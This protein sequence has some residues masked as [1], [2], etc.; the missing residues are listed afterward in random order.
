M[1]IDFI[2]HFIIFLLACVLMFFVFNM[3]YSKSPDYSLDRKLDVYK[4]NQK[5]LEV[6]KSLK[7]KKIINLKIIRKISQKLNSG[8]RILISVLFPIIILI[9]AIPI[10]EM[11]NCC[12]V[13]GAFQLNETWWFWLISIG[14]IGYVEF[15]LFSD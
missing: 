13:E 12:G 15:Y 9:I 5:R 4:E 11:I 2:L 3:F 1:E 7:K 8:Q 14:L 10:G 6:E